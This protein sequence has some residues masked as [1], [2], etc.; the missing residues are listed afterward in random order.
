MDGNDLID[1]GPG[2]RCFLCA[3]AGESF[4]NPDGGRRQ[5]ILAD[6]SIGEVMVLE[7]EP[8]NRY[9][10]EAVKVLREKTGEQ[11]G[12]L[13]RD[14]GLFDDVE[15]GRVRAM[16]FSVH[17]GTREKPSRGAVLQIGIKD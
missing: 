5:D 13:P 3:V 9:D 12:Y 11:I 16:L 8:G 2:W 14:H 6:C 1:F 4:T 10:R 17:G 7:P 15:E